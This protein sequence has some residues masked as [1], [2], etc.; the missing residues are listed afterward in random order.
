MGSCAVW[1]GGGGGSKDFAS[2]NE[3]TKS[4]LKIV[5][6]Q[7]KMIKTIFW[8]TKKIRGVIETFSIIE[9]FSMT[10]KIFDHR[11]FLGDFPENY[12]FSIPI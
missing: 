6:G 2:K 7:R 8:V 10:E 3:V 9:K 4:C 5:F 11:M 12:V 1:V